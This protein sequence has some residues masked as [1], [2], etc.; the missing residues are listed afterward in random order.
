M[1]SAVARNV[2]VFCMLFRLKTMHGN[3]KG[4]ICIVKV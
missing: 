4:K 3:G 1:K 2:H